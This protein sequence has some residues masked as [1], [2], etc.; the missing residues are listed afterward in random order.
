MFI[1]NLKE[2]F[3]DLNMSKLPE[4]MQARFFGCFFNS[5]LQ[6]FLF[7]ILKVSFPTVCLTEIVVKLKFHNGVCHMQ[8][9]PFC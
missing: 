8:H 7:Y 5:F 1:F 2:R 4:Q 3:A 6:F 9:L